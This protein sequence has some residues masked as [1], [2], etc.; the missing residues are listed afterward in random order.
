MMT[1]IRTLITWSSIQAR[2]TKMKITI[3]EAMT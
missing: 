3:V 1:I 2:L